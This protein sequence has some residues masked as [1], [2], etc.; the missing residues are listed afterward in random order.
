MIKCEQ[1]PNRRYLQSYE[2]AVDKNLFLENNPAPPP[3]LK[4]A[5]FYL[6]IKGTFTTFGQSFGGVPAGGTS[7]YFCFPKKETDEVRLV[8]YNRKFNRKSI[9]Y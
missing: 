5:L 8:L 9:N 6:S 1:H 2:N 4:T 7:Q 3:P